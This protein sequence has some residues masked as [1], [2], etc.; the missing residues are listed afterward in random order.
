[1]SQHTTGHTGLLCLLGSPVAHSI[2]PE[3]HNEACALLDAVMNA[4]LER[5]GPGAYGTLTAFAAWW[6][7]RGE[8]PQKAAALRLFRCVGFEM[9]TIAF[10]LSTLSLAVTASSAP[11]SLSK[12]FFCSSIVTP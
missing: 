10:F 7:D 5:V 8:A 4:P 9:E 6:L 12:Q 3:M 2:S 1:M 11:G